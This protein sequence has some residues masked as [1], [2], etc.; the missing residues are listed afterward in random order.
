MGAAALTLIF[1]AALAHALWNLLAKRA[2]GGASFVWLVE[3]WAAAIYLPVAAGAVAWTSPTVDGT[4]L[5]F[6]AGNAVLHTAYFLTLQ[7]GYRASDLSLVY[8]VARGTGPLLAT[9]AAVIVLGERPTALAVL[10]AVLIA[11]GVLLL[12][13]RRGVR[14]SAEATGIGFG[15]LTGL[16]IAA[17][18][19]WDKQAVGP[20]AIQ[21]VL[22]DWAGTLGRALLLSPVAAFRGS[23]VH[24]VWRRNR[25]EVL[26]VALLSPLAYIL[27]LVALS[28]TPVS[29]VAPAREVSIPIGAF[30]GVRLLGEPQAGRR[31]AA[32]VAVATG[33]V[34]LALG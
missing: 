20:L 10:G 2:G 9:A 32:A 17:Y 7:A 3:A 34:A 29:Y 14:G 11:G 22:Y 8:P 16:L 21:P 15:V 26:G 27:V 19:L 31:L 28:F 18:T 25:R 5:A 23:E 1:G 4:D 6:M 33:V 12:A 30:L 13:G 24:E